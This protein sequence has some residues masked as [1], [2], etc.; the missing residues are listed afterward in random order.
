MPDIVTLDFETFWSAEHTLRKMTPIAY[1]MS[2]LTQ[3]ISLAAKVNGEPTTCVF[4]ESDIRALL[5]DID[6]SNKI[7]V[8]HNM[9]TFDALLLAWRLGLN[10][11]MYLCTLAMARP[12]YGKVWPLGLGSLVERL[13]LGRKDGQVLLDT[14]G[15][16]L[17]DFTPEE[18]ARMRVYNSEDTDQCFALFRHLKQF[19]TSAELWHVDATIR[20]F[21]DPVFELDV[22]LL[23]AALSVERSN[24]HKALLDLAR[25]LGGVKGEG[26]SNEQVI[27]D[28]MRKQMAS[29]QKFQALLESREVDV[30]M[31]RSKTDPH[32]FIP[33]IAKTDEAMQELLDDPDEVVAAAARARLSVKS[34][35]LETRIQS[36]LDAYK[37]V[38]KLP[39][40]AHYC[41]ADTTGR[42]SGFLYNMYN[43]PRI[44]PDKPKVS[45]AL[46]KSVRAPRGKKIGVADLSGIELRVN[47]TLWKVARSMRLWAGDPQADLYKGT[48][49]YYY[50]IPEAEVQKPQRQ[51]GKVLELACFAAGT[52]VV[53]NSGPKPIEHVSV[54]DLVWDGQEWV[55]HG[56]VVC[57]GTKETLEHSAVRATP[58]HEVLTAGGWVA[59]SEVRRC[60]STFQSALSSATSPWP[61][62][63]AALA[64][65]APATSPCAGAHAGEH[66]DQRG[67]TSAK[68]APPG[69]THV[70]SKPRPEQ[71]LSAAARPSTLCLAAPLGAAFSA[72]KMPPSADATTRTTEGTRTTGAGASRS[73]RRGAAAP[74]SSCR[75][76]APC[77]AGISRGSTWTGSTTTAVT[78]QG[79]SGSSPAERTAATN[80]PSASLSEK[81]NASGQSLPVFDLVN[82]GPRHRFTILTSDGPIV[83]HNCGF[84]IG[85]DGRTLRHQAR[86]QYGLKLTIEQ[87]SSGVR[88][89][90]ARYPEIA[91]YDNGGWARCQDMLR[92]IQAGQEEAIDPWGLCHTTK[93]GIVGPTGRMIRYPELRVERVTKLVEVDGELVEKKSDQWV[94][95][96]GRHKAYLYGGKVDENLVQFLAREIIFEMG[97][98]FWKRTGLRMNHKVY[99]ELVYAF[100]E[101]EAEALLAELLAVMR[102][103]PR[104]WKDITLW[105]EGDLADCYGDAK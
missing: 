3:L 37:A 6:V 57:R 22:G 104:W 94:Y 13:G 19:F 65:T 74:G 78:S 95:A 67:P 96:H 63:N 91:D 14:R 34:T 61:A 84:G 101:N 79:T 23:H 35:Q 11:R 38:G 81:C 36:F 62:T 31:K 93:D 55:H 48:A 50:Q 29:A 25:V 15:K 7:V 97:L 45:D 85:V 28:Q 47:H 16:R 12:V 51:F 54:L 72:A 73:S 56:G 44:N 43:L 68:G 42:D 8:G 59:W 76:S 52:L 1:A 105:A 87:A 75:T 30:P 39:V 69:A 92:Y 103:S 88:A 40:P 20:M 32:K 53:T 10:P 71:T 64:A 89:W 24:K 27:V 60:P 21:V 86:A 49:A 102:T 33:A 80:E 17:E 2:E 5:A 99:D 82:C 83:V 41:G 90:R 70:R 77:L 66:P 9:S 46:R 58:D 18:L 100:P 26:W 4:G 98:E